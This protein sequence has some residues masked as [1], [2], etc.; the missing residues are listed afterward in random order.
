MP[1]P[2]AVFRCRYRYHSRCHCRCHSRFRFHCRSC[3]RFHWDPDLGSP[4]RLLCCSWH[5]SRCYWR[6]GL[7]HRAL[8]AEI[9]TPSGFDFEPPAPP[10]AVTSAPFPIPAGCDMDD[11]LATSTALPLSS[12]V[13]E[14]FVPFTTA[15]RS[16]V[17]TSKCPGGPLPIS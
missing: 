15:T 17:S 14:N 5:C 4:F 8:P 2:F 16:G 11:A 6:P 13:T 10:P 7:L 1:F 9:E 3:Y 12:T